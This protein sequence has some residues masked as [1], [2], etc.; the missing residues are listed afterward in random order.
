MR[1]PNKTRHNNAM[2]KVLRSFANS[3]MKCSQPKIEMKKSKAGIIQVIV[4][5]QR[6]L[7]FVRQLR[8]FAAI[9]TEQ[10]RSI[11]ISNT[12]YCETKHTV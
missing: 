7:S 12:V 9:F 5:I 10:N 3:P 4:T 2:T 1:W 6:T 8:Y 11:V